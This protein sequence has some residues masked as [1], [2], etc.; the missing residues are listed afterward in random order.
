MA[1]FQSTLVKLIYFVD[2]ICRHQLRR[3][4]LNR[5]RGR[6]TLNLLLV[7]LARLLGGQV[8]L[9]AVL[10]VH[11]KDSLNAEPL[12]QAQGVV[13]CLGPFAADE[14][15]NL[16]PSWPRCNSGHHPQPHGARLRGLAASIRRQGVRWSKFALWGTGRRGWI[17]T[18]DPCPP[19]CDSGGIDEMRPPL[20]P[21]LQPR[22][23]SPQR[24]RAATR[25]RGDAGSARIASKT[26][27]LA[28][29][30]SPRPHPGHRRPR[31]RPDRPIFLL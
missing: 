18:G 21:P 20:S 8:K 15:I 4:G 3:A 14:L 13:G 16:H 27:L 5:R 22:V 23:P 2:G 28:Q 1:P 26:P 6:T 17:V 9:I 10:Q 29:P 25:Q 19:C 7:L 12:F 11:P 24:R 30:R 31:P